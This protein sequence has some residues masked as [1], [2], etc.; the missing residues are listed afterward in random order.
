MYIQGSETSKKFAS[1]SNNGID[2]R[3]KRLDLSTPAVMGIINLSPH[4]FSAV[5]R[6]T[7][8]NDAVQHAIKL[9]EAGASILDI[10]AEPTNPA[11]S[12]T[13]TEAEELACLLPVIRELVQAVDVPLSVDT[14]CPKVMHAV[15]EAGAHMINDVRALRLPGALAMMSQLPV[16]VC[17]MHMR[18]LSVPGVESSPSA[19]MAPD[20]VMDEIQQFL[21][22]RIQAAEAAGIARERIVIDPGIGAGCFGKTTEEN[23]R[24]LRELEQLR[25]FDLP[26]L[27]GVSRK[28][29]LGDLLNIPVTERLAASLIAAMAAVRRGAHIIR[30]HDVAETVHALT[31][32]RAIEGDFG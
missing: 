13:V 27:V 3:G 24:I 11:Q 31:V 20:A 21:V 29:F 17:L 9:V 23:I 1:S 15:V 16:P 32:L 26:I 30:V 14:S 7:S 5:G 18:Y 12:Q 2:C 6:V 8:V 28:R 25:H 22:E 4:S 10:G 19:T